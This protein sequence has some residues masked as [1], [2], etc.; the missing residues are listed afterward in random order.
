[1]PW[2]RDAPVPTASK[3]SYNRWHHHRSV[4][5]GIQAAGRAAGGIPGGI[6]ESLLSTGEE[7]AVLTDTNTKCC[8]PT[9]GIKARIKNIQF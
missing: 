8:K 9:P 3:N 4:G 2:A 5:A 6:L 7:R 1:M